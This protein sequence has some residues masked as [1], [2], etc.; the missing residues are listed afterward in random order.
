MKSFT[1]IA[2][3]ITNIEIYPVP[4]SIMWITFPVS[5]GK[6]RLIY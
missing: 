2:A 1:T 3:L 6:D 5:S 4:S